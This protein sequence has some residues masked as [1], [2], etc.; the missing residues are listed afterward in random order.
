MRRTKSVPLVFGAA[1]AIVAIGFDW[2]L[3]ATTSPF[4]RDFLNSVWLPNLWLRLNIV[5]T[6]A[7]LFANHVIAGN[8]YAGTRAGWV[9]YLIALGAQWF[10][11][12]FL[13][14]FVI[15]ILAARRE[16]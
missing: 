10:V 13:V 4:Y 16:P 15:K 8:M 6:I 2:V 1:T 9:A 11:I 14:S 5:A 12:G 3:L 7:R